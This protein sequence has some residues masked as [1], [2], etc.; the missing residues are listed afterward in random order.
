MS[1]SRNLSTFDSCVDFTTSVH[2]ACFS[3]CMANSIT[4]KL[5]TTVFWV[6]LWACL[7]L[8]FGCKLSLPLKGWVSKSVLVKTHVAAGIGCLVVALAAGGCTWKNRQPTTHP[9]ATTRV[10]CGMTC[11]PGCEWHPFQQN[12]AFWHCLRVLQCPQ[13]ALLPVPPP[14]LRPLRLAHRRPPP[15]L[16]NKAQHQNQVCLDGH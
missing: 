3:C 12:L 13:Q 11:L 10:H 9:G 15:K 8:T 14:K 16:Q 1:N 5:S 6:V 7:F 4:E 2:C